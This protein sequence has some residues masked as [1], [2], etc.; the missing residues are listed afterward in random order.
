MGLST[1]FRRGAAGKTAATPP[2]PRSSAC[3][4][5]AALPW[6]LTEEIWEHRGQSRQLLAPPL[7][8]PEEEKGAQSREA[9]AG[10]RGEL[11]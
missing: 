7:V 9:K 8:P 6:A 2:G 1:D 10:G 4:T 3:K 11:G 5:P